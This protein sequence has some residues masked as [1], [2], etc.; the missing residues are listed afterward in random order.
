MNL[1]PFEMYTEIAKHLSIK[2][3][4]Q[5]IQI[6][7]LLNESELLDGIYDKCYGKLPSY[8]LYNQY[9]HH[10]SECHYY[11]HVI[12]EDE[13]FILLEHERCLYINYIKRLEHFNAE[14]TIMITVD[15]NHYYRVYEFLPCV[16]PLSISPEHYYDEIDY[17][18]YILNKMITYTNINDFTFTYLVKHKLTYEIQNIFKDLQNL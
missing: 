1:L 7:K 6:N 11:G 16:H 2:D 8:Q 9:S 10:K 17:D 14:S 4:T 15:K 13:Q 12:L 5:L 18:V 3:L